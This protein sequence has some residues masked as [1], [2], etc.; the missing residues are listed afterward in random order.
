MQRGTRRSTSAGNFYKHHH[1]HSKQLTQSHPEASKRQRAT[2]TIRQDVATPGSCDVF[3]YDTPPRS[4][5]QQQK[6]NKE[7]GA[8]RTC[9]APKLP[10]ALLGAAAT[11][12]V[13]TTPVGVYR[14]RQPA[15][16]RVRERHAHHR[17]KARSGP[18]G[19]GEQG[20]WD[21]GTCAAAKLPNEGMAR[22]PDGAKG[23]NGQDH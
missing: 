15:A 20:E 5:L 23:A 2:S 21:R 18:R 12:A 9:H 19:M 3:I 7:Y 8:P 11:S 1:G 13:A 4:Q 17:A 14:G 6:L 16:D 22:G 10:P